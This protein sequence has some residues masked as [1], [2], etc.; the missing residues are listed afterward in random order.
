[1]LFAPAF[2]PGQHYEQSVPAVRQPRRIPSIGGGGTEMAFHKVRDP[3]RQRYRV[4]STQKASQM[5]AKKC[6]CRRKMAACLAQPLLGTE[7][8]EHQTSKRLPNRNFPR[9]KMLLKSMTLRHVFL[10]IV[11]EEIRP[12]P[13]IPLVVD[14]PA[15]FLCN[16]GRYVLNRGLSISM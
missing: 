4:S 6:P 13:A 16:A 8:T 14:K 1:M 2:V 3:Q 7:Q 10:T 12:R 15:L 9:R 5:I 11:R